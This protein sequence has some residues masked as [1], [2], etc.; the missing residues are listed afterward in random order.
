[1][2]HRRIA[3]GADCH[4]LRGDPSPGLSRSVLVGLVNLGEELALSS[5]GAGLAS[6]AAAQ[7]EREADGEH[8]S[9]EGTGDVDPILA[10]VGAYEV[11]T[12]GACRVHRSARDRA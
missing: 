7:H 10:E 4:L 1:M 3:A 11:G 5:A 6:A 8:C 12:E 2:W 9:R